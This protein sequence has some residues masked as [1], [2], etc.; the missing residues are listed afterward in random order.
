M[1]NNH[2]LLVLILAMLG[3]FFGML[4]ISKPNTIPFW[5]LSGCSPLSVGWYGEYNG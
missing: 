3:V 5:S 1:D 4:Y 2:I